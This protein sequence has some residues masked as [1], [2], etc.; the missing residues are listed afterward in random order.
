MSRE[1]IVTVRVFGSVYADD[2]EEA[3][4]KARDFVWDNL[5]GAKIDGTEIES[6]E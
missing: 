4:E 6:V 1:W 2:E 5:T 3:V